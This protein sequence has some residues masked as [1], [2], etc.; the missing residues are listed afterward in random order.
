VKRSEAPTLA[1]TALPLSPAAT[2]APA[3]SSPSSSP[4][5]PYGSAACSFGVTGSVLAWV[6]AGWAWVGGGEIQCSGG[7][8]AIGNGIGFGLGDLHG[9]GTYLEPASYSQTWCDKTDSDCTTEWFS[10]SNG[11]CVV[12]VTSAPDAWQVGA[13]VAGTFT[14]GPLANTEDPTR[15]V[16]IYAGSFAAVVAPPP[17]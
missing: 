1:L 7:A 12:D 4:S 17:D 11:A 10:A 6:G 8:G 5:N 9:P 16:T 15:V 14:C 3:S 13:N 2:A